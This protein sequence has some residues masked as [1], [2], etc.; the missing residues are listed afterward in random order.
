MKKIPTIFLEYKDY[1]KT[2]QLLVKFKYNDYLLNLLRKIPAA[3][4]STSLK[5]WY[6]KDTKE[7]LNLIISTFKGITTIDS[8]K[9]TKKKNFKR[10][11]TDSEKTLLNNFYLYLKGKRYSKSTIQTYT[12]FIADFINFHTKT[13]LAELT[14]RDVELFIETVFIERKYSISSQRQFISALKIFIV[15]YPQT[16]IND[17]SLERPKKSRTLPNVLSQEEVLR[18]IQLT[19]NLKHRAIIVLLYS[20]GLRIGEVTGLL[21][22]N[23]DILRKQIKVE[24]GKGR[25]DRFVVLATSY[26]PLL[27]NYLTTFKP[28]LYFI[29][30]PTGKKYSESSIRK[31]LFKSVQ[32][33]GISKK[34]TPHTLRHSYATHLLENGVGLRHIQELLGHAKPETTMI[35]THVA[36]KDLLDIQSPLDT[37]LLNLDK[38]DKREQKFL[39]SG[40]RNL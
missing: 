34:V 23:I 33:A 21:L 20:S 7:N 1:K 11:L 36:K 38:N 29:E 24:G 19:K 9:L 32:K 4:W 3:T 26:L 17:L 37:I 16:K 39:L 28:A 22:K 27:H 12:L 5:T 8:S 15:F 30:G 2:P 6:L 14:N 35:Y 10:N 40:N 13:P 25:K 31:F 18:I